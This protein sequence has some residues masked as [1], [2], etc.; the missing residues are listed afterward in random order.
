V[1]VQGFAVSAEGG[2]VEHRGLVF[3]AGGCRRREDVLAVV[4]ADDF[5][6]GVVF[7]GGKGTMV[8]TLEVEPEIRTLGAF[9]L[10]V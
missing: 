4:G 9:L 6:H 8:T 10:E 5:A 1:F 7:R 2:V 3:E